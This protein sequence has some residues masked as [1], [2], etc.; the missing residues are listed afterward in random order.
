[1]SSGK[2]IAKADG[3]RRVEPEMAQRRRRIFLKVLAESGNVMRAAKAVGYTNSSYV[4]RLRREDPVFAEQWDAAMQA[5]GDVLES[6]AL[7]RGV[8]GVEKPIM[9]KGEIVAHERQFSD[10]LL[11]TL[12]KANNPEKFGDKKTIVGEINH[13]GGVM[14]VPGMIVSEKD[15]EQQSLETHDRQKTLDAEFTVV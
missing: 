13:K 3:N 12:L 2:A 14:I 11:Q 5:A 7:R 10:G 9:Y 8:E 1:M 15:W 4:R 6:E